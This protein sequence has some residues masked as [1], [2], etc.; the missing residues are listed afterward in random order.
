MKELKA[1]I[2]IIG[3][4]LTGLTTAYALSSLKKKIILVDRGKL[5]STKTHVDFRTTAISQGSKQFF[6]KIGIWKNLHRF[7]QP[8]KFIK[9]QD[10]SRSRIIDFRNKLSEENLGY[11]VSNKDIKKT[12]L[13][14]LKSKKNVIIKEN[15]NFLSLVAKQSETE[16]YFNKIKI[17]S[18]LVI[19]SDGKKS[20]VRNYLKTKTFSKKYSH[21]ALV[22]N[23]NHTKNHHNTAYEIFFKSGPL[24]ILPTKNID[25]NKFSSSLIWTN[26]SE[27][28]NELS[29]LKI[30]FLKSILEEKIFQYSGSIKKIHSVQFFPLSAHI[31][32]KFFEKRL[33]Y[34]G[35]A[36]HSMHPIAGQGWNVGVRDI[37]KC[38]KVLQESENM[39]LD[40]G[41]AQICRKFNNLCYSDSFS[42]Y[43]ITD[44]LNS[45]FLSEGLITDF[46]RFLGF[47][48]I[49]K[50]ELLK[51]YITNFAMGVK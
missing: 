14:K 42:L 17:I 21:S 18:N 5:F 39:G 45:I 11:I 48:F 27:Y 20:S 1:D 32:S 26:K 16:T 10:R 30:N 41:S 4:G 19:A 44:K 8:I 2:L 37:E 34:I 49:Q 24:A 33:F 12:F 6:E 3:G 43:Q 46:T 35:D 50:N 31:N 38:L 28:T 51:N 29:K 36:A 22:V 13:N 9:V 7:S 15:L 47:K 23:F 25:I 40:I